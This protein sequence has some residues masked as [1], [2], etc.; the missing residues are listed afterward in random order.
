MGGRGLLPRQQRFVEEYLVDLNATQA[1]VRAGYSAKTANEQGARLLANV[2]VQNAIRERQA[3]RSART[4]VTQDWVLR[5]YAMIAGVDKR[6]FFYD[7]GSLKP[8]SEWTEEMAA[9]VGGFDAVESGGGEGVPVV[10]KRL[11]FLDGKAA[12]D[13]MARHLGMFKDK[14]EVSVDESLAERLERARSRLNGG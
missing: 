2:S 10:L 6:Q 5:R 13:S 12:L 1:A 9:A 7:D 3:A 14:V 11:K 8:V 4:E